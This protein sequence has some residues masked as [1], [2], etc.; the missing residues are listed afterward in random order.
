MS[1][2]KVCNEPLV[3]RLDDDADNDD[4]ETAETV[5]DD[6][7]LG[8]GCHFH[9]E[10][11][12]E[13]ASTVATSLKCPSCDIYLPRNQAGASSTTQFREASAAAILAQ[14]SNEGGV[15]KDL[16]IMASITEE[17]YVQAHPEARPARAF[18]VMCAEGDIAGVIDLLRD[19]SDQG[20]DAGSIIRYQDPLE[21]MKS[22]LHLA[23]ENKQ[24][25]IVWTLLWLSSRI[26]TDAF[27]PLVRQMAEGVGLGRINV[28]ADGDVRC[29]RDSQGRV[30]E[31]IAQ[32][33]P[34]VWS[35]LLDG[36]VLSP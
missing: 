16:D 9:W 14:Y 18:H 20:A 5:P 24:D 28:D 29:L 3:L 7:E 19:A 26:S 1:A 27:P 12:M 6:L 22:G 31:T 13:E 32:Q 4:T 25:E 2:C 35:A 34:E 23:V 21:G 33:N 8:C 11:L 15:Q 30:A 17:A 10:C 36:G